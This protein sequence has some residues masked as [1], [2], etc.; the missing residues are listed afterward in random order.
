MKL[1][2]DETVEIRTIAGDLK[3]IVCLYHGADRMW[4]GATSRG[5]RDLSVMAKRSIEAGRPSAPETE[6]QTAGR[7]DEAFGILE[8]RSVRLSDPASAIHTV[9]V[10]D[11]FRIVGA[12]LQHR[13]HHPQIRSFWDFCGHAT[14]ECVVDGRK[15]E[16]CLAP[17]DAVVGF[18]AVERFYRRW[19]FIQRDFDGILWNMGKAVAASGGAGAD[20]IRKSVDHEMIAKAERMIAAMGKAVMAVRTDAVAEA[21]IDVLKMSKFK[22]IP[23]DTGGFVRLLRKWDGGYRTFSAHGSTLLKMVAGMPP[24][25]IPDK[26]AE[27]W[28][29]EH[30]ALNVTYLT[31]IS[32]GS[33]DVRTLTACAGGRWGAFNA[34][35]KRSDQRQS[36]ARDVIRAFRQQV[37]MPSLCRAVAYPDET[38]APDEGL[39][40]AMVAALLNTEAAERTQAASW[41]LLFGRKSMPAVMEKIADWHRRNYRIE[42]AIGRAPDAVW[43]APFERFVH[44]S[45]EIVPIAD[46][47]ELRAEGDAMR[48]CVGGNAYV[49][50]C[51]DRKSVIVSMRRI[52]NGIRTRLS[53]A[54]LTAWEPEKPWRPGLVQHAGI[55]NAEPSLDAAVALEAMLEAFALGEHVAPKASV[56]ARPGIDGVSDQA[57]YDWMNAGKVENAIR[58]WAHFLPGDVVRCGVGWFRDNITEIVGADAVVELRESLREAIVMVDRVGRLAASR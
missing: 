36:E 18:E 5:R 26:I 21:V 49:R 38:V 10:F 12:A 27:R 24:D 4:W 37:M 40:H 23:D 30:A 3:A 34:R 1:T 6:D 52:E 58:Q 39:R 54:E 42:I 55:R 41:R 29:F 45:I 14:A 35:V 16:I 11:D 17:L 47:R 32:E 25:W 19:N 8:K 7:M 56:A 9:S 31:A 13:G 44:G 28:S 48:H 20:D 33:L 50:G 53:T 57:G 46:S 51:I 2:P 15:P 22:N 43:D